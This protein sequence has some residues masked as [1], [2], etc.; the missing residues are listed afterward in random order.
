MQPRLF[1]IGKVAAPKGGSNTT[2]A[3]NW[4][5]DRSVEYAS[6]PC[7]P[8]RITW[9]L[10]REPTG[11]AAARPLQFSGA[12]VPHSAQRLQ[13]CIA[14]AFGV[15]GGGRFT[16][17]AVRMC[18]MRGRKYRARTAA[19]NFFI[20]PLACCFDACYC[21]KHPRV[22]RPASWQ[23]GLAPIGVADAAAVHR[24]FPHNLISDA[25]RVVA[26]A[27]LLPICAFLVAS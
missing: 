27:S 18:Q 6:H 3:F 5:G 8:R 19:R 14:P 11:I 1:I 15:R 25:L 22:A 24:I 16:G 21:L 20:S 17:V 12:S 4:A 13:S 2:L 9:D 7:V 26:H 23:I 10:L